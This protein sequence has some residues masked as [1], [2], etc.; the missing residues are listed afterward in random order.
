MNFII[1]GLFLYLIGFIGFCLLYLSG[2]ESFANAILIISAI[3][4]LV[5]AIFI[6]RELFNKKVFK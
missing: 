6:F 4:V 2:V 1:V 5:G 3:S